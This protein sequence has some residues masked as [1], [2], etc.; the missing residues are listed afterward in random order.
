MNIMQTCNHRESGSV[1]ELGAIEQHFYL[2][3]LDFPFLCFSLQ[4]SLSEPVSQYIPVKN[5]SPIN[6]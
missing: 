6:R 2:R 1:P 3:S 5:M 4:I